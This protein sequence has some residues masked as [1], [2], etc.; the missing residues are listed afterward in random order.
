LA[1][2]LAAVCHDYD[3]LCPFQ[4][5][6][7]S[8]HDQRVGFHDPKPVDAMTAREQL[9]GPEA[10][11]DVV[12]EGAQDGVLFATNRAARQR[13]AVTAGGEQLG[14]YGKRARENVELVVRQELDQGVG[15]R[16][17]ADDDAFAWL[18]E[19]CRCPGDRAFL[20]HVDVLAQRESHADRMRLA[21][22]P[23]RFCAATDAPELTALS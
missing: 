12:L 1:S 9:A 21:T 22:G 19:R 11:H 7:L 6:C 18:D 10:T 4:E 13:H 17:A 16:A 20:R 15:G 5:L 2:Q 3:M 8:L 23:N 14:G